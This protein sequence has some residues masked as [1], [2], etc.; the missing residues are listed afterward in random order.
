M[1]EALNFMDVVVLCSLIFRRLEL[2]EPSENQA[3]F[4]GDLAG[5]LAIR[6][7][8]PQSSNVLTLSESPAF[9][10]SYTFQRSK[11]KHRLKRPRNTQNA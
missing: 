10:S 7:H 4:Y 5:E 2:V 6:R 3:R 8:F 1:G 11:L 9:P